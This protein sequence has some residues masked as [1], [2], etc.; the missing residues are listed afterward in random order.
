MTTPDPPEGSFRYF[1]DQFRSAYFMRGERGQYLWQTLVGIPADEAAEAWFLCSRMHLLADAESP[2]DVLPLLSKDRRLPRYPL[3]TEAQHRAR[4]LGAWSIYELG[5]TERVI[6]T[7]IRAAG[8]GPTAQIDRWAQPG[9]TWGQSGFTWAN[10]GAFVQFRPQATGP[11]GEAAPYRTQFWLVF[12]EGFHPVIDDMIPWGEFE[13]GDHSDGVWSY[14]GYTDDL[15]RTLLGIVYKWKPSDHVFRGF[16]FRLGG[17]H[18]WA[19]PGHAW[20]E[21]PNRWGNSLDVD[22]ELGTAIP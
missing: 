12:G 11:R 9:L 15:I 19:A 14:I 7:Q 22:V 20:A 2:D 10:V 4:L 18:T 6:E 3:E 16:R 17:I 1:L 21:M 8:Y 13:W 5:G